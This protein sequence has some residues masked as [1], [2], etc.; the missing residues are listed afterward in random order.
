MLFFLILLLVLVVVVIIKGAYVVEQQTQC[1]IE[2]LGKFHITAGPG[3]HVKIPLVDRIAARMNLRISQS[4]MD[5]TAKTLDNV[6]LRMRVAVQ[7][8]VDAESRDGVF[9]AYYNLSDPEAQMRSYVA[10]SLRSSVPKHTLDDV[11]AAKDDLAASVQEGISGLMLENGYRIEN[12][13]ITA[14]ELPHDV[15]QSM[16]NINSAQREQEAAKALAEAERIKVVTE[17]RAQAEAME[18]A[19]KGIAAQRKAIADGIADSLETIKTSGVSTQEANT[20]FLYTQWTDMMEKFAKTG[21]SSTVV[22][23]SDFSQSAG[24]FEQLL[25]ADK[26]TQSDAAP[27]ARVKP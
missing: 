25:C 16:N 12:T 5:V 17:A 2:R 20:L 15:E 14:I 19:G 23:P 6:T 4:E 8:R 22:L 10:D 26:A 11:F 7:W 9:R 3:F 18:Q 27:R 24:M 13:L 1:V 21:R